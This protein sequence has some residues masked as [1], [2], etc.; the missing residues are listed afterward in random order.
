[1]DY[2]SAELRQTLHPVDDVTSAVTFYGAAFGFAPK[3][4]DGD[5]F[6]ALGAGGSTLALVGPAENVTGGQAAAGVKVSDLPAALRSIVAA[7]EPSY[8]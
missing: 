4:T 8:A 6:A 1:M 3:F 5:R 2:K 7:V